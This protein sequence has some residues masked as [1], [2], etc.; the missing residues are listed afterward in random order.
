MAHTQTTK[1]YNVCAFTAL[2]VKMADMMYDLGH[3][4][5][6]YAG[7]ENDARCTELITC[8]SKREQK[9]WGKVTGP[10]NILNA[11]FDRDSRL[12]STFNK[13]AIKAMNARMQTGDITLY[14]QGQTQEYV[15]SAMPDNQRIEYAVGYAGQ[16]EQT[17][18]I[19]PSQAWMHAMYGRWYGC[20]AT[21]GRV[22]DRVIPHYFD[23]D[24]F[25]IQ[26]VKKPYFAFVGRMNH[27]KGPGIAVEAAKA[28]G[29]PLVVAGL[30]EYQFPDWVT[31]LGLIGPEERAQLMGEASALFVPTRYLEPFGK[32][33][34]EAQLVG[35]PAI[36]SDWGGFPE[37]VVNG[38]T[39]WR[40]HTQTD[41]NKAGAKALA[42]A[43][44][45]WSVARASRKKFDMNVIRY[46]YEDYF[47]SLA[48]EGKD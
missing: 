39:G 41:F 40:C 1:E 35:T 12:W 24:D 11:G 22:Y 8:I 6:L 29:V 3:E 26:P 13:R 20:H 28:N 7:D 19:Y 34:V 36:T 37:T 2:A 48:R 45:P 18:R 17:H 27:D 25:P 38:V 32:V 5:F 14:S 42:G 23:L 31:Q 46:E 44:E 21:Q 30:G 43:L 33:A 4:V 47:K 9:R 16:S 10:H 15:M